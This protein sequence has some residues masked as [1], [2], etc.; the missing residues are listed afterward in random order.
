MCSA[1]EDQKIGAGPTFAYNYIWVLRAIPIMV[2]KCKCIRLNYTIFIGPWVPQQVATKTQATE[3]QPSDK[4]PTTQNLGPHPPKST[5]QLPYR[6]CQVGVLV[7]QWVYDQ[8]ERH[9]KTKMAPKCREQ[10]PIGSNLK[11]PNDMPRHPQHHEEGRVGICSWCLKG[12]ALL[13]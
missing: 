1:I 13:G 8:V 6:M 10:N 11:Q 3:K 12:N 2:V 4:V 9:Q 5:V 7:G